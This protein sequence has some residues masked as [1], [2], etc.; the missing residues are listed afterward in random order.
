ML[1]ELQTAKHPRPV[2]TRSVRASHRHV[3][4]CQGGAL[5][6]LLTCRGGSTHCRLAGTARGAAGRMVRGARARARARVVFLLCRVQPSDDSNAGCQTTD[7]RAAGGRRREASAGGCVVPT[8]SS[9]FRAGKGEVRQRRVSGWSRCSLFVSSLAL[10]TRGRRGG[11]L[12][13]QG[14]PRACL[15]HPRPPQ[16]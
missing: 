15:R 16:F 12:G 7:T 3:T 8:R 6:T 13:A 2:A 11:V 14:P 9:R 10:Y 4:A 5:L 1:Q